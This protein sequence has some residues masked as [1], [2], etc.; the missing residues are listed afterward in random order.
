MTNSAAQAVAPLPRGIILAAT[1]LGNIG[2]ASPRLKQA[3]AEADYI[4][5][6][7]TRRTRQLALALG[8]DIRGQVLSNFDHN[9]DGRAQQLIDYARHATV[10]VVTDAGMPLVSDP[11]FALVEKAHDAGIPITCF[12]GPSAVTTALA[13]SGLQVGKFAF[14]GFAPRKSG[15]RRSW[16]ESLRT[17]T[18][19]VCFF[20]S[21]HRIAD[22][23]AQAV[24]VL[25]PDRRAAVVRELTK[26]F[27]EV[28]R[29]S[30]AEL[31]QWASGGLRGEITVV[32]EGVRTA[33]LRDVSEL[34][35][36]V[37]QLVTTGQRL[38]DACSQVA[39]E[40]GVRKKELYDAVLKAR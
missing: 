6:E 34:V 24:E 4:A 21:P 19:T 38:K 30:L 25:G 7:D 37:E 36:E 26:T 9:E 2:D 13:L 18:R 40:Y 12:P 29:A 16:L 15:Q 39:K 35:D 31:A 33:V 10:V 3:L 20:E 22:T 5:A 28:K 17:E 14:D 8:V 27:E 1:P 23:L 11:G 32:I